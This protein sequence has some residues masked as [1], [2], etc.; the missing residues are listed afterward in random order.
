[1]RCARALPASL[2]AALLTA[3]ALAAP[4]HAQ[5]YPSKTVRL[6]VPYAPGGIVDYAGRLLAQRLA[7]GFS[8]NVV[9][10]NRPGAGGVIGVDITSKATPDG[11][12]LVI[13]DPAI[14]INPSL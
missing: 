2:V 1:M 13:M 4:A 11:Y 7:E 6:I 10:D 9:I 14:V 8:Q 12:T 5:R 3:C